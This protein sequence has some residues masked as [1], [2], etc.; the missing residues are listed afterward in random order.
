VATPAVDRAL[1][2]SDSNREFAS[3]L[4]SWLEG[5]ACGVQRVRPGV[6]LLRPRGRVHVPFDVEVSITRC[7]K[8]P[9]AL[10]REAAV[11]GKV[12][13]LRAGHPL[14][15][16]IAVHLTESDRGVAFAMLRHA[17]GVWPPAVVARADVSSRVDRSGVLDVRGL[18]PELS[19]RVLDL[20]VGLLP[21]ELE[22]VWFF[23][24]GDEVTHPSVLR[25]Y[26]RDTGDLNLGSRPEAFE[27]LTSHLDWESLCSQGT[28][29]ALGLTRT[30]LVE[31]SDRA[32]RVEL[33]LARI[34]T[35][36]DQRRTRSAAG[37]SG[38]EWVLDGDTI[39]R[40]RRVLME[41]RSTVIGAGVIFLAD[42]QLAGLE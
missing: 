28:N 9:L 37:L 3:A 42:R 16:A 10:S 20:S 24:N 21:S 6:I 30:R 18:P 2:D 33:L 19:Q 12:E 17:T 38:D 22:S 27:E 34:M 14:V 11:S 41:P 40:L 31:K 4:T 26:S 29:I 36:I 23:P 25:A 35:E 5:V 8:T 1:M 13:V 15:D 7:L 39:E 32:E